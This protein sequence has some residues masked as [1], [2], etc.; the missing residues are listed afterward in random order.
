M[1]LFY[2]K[3]EV[4]QSKACT[5]YFAIETEEITVYFGFLS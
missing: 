3:T 4:N 2:Y 1:T 5:D